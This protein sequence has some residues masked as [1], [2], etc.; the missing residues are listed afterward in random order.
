MQNTDYSCQNLL[1]VRGLIATPMSFQRIEQRM[2][3][4]NNLGTEW[5][6]RH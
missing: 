4:T 5:C 2:N 3:S 1:N 6:S